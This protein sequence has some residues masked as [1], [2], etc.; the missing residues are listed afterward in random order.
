MANVVKSN[1]GGPNSPEAHAMVN[2][3]LHTLSEITSRATLAAKL[4]QS[5][6]GKR[7]LYEAL[8]YKL[9]PE[10]DDYLALY[11]RQELARAVINKPVNA[12]WSNPPKVYDS[13]AK[14]TPFENQWEE[15]CKTLKVWYHFRRV[16]RLACIGRYAVL[17]IGLDDVGSIEDLGNPASVGAKPVYLN[18]Y[19]ERSAVINQWDQDPKSPRYGMP[20]SYNIAV[21]DGT[22]DRSSLVHFSRV[23]HVAHDPLESVTFGQ[24]YLEA[25]INRLW[26]LEL[27]LGGAAEGFWRGGFPGYNFKL[28]PGAKFDQNLDEFKTEIDSFVHGMKRYLRLQG[29]SVEQLGQQIADPSQLVAALHQSIACG[30]DI[31]VRILIGSERGELASSSDDQS[32]MRTIGERQ[33]QE[34]EQVILRP[35]IEKFQDLGAL[36]MTPNG[37][38]VEWPALMAKGEKE[39]AQVGALK[40][41]A[42]QLY[43]SVMSSGVQKVLPIKSFLEHVL[44]LT[45]NQMGQVEEELKKDPPPEIKTPPPS[46]F[47]NPFQKGF[48]PGNPSQDPTQPAPRGVPFR[49]KGKPQTE[50]SANRSWV[51]KLL[52]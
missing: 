49:S 9:N 26:N 34:C 12:S 6:E 36:P 17:H 48:P 20:V 42:L 10:F 5:Y 41:R 4:G 32:W 50:P 21:T 15:L 51:Q 7:K 45:P 13:V 2:E 31:P 18:T 38:E 44:H 19:S 37:F 8:G 28:D 1:G 39:Q 29:I 11:S 24:P 23:V 52:P 25:V 43:A 22:S 30:E 46:P 47:G 3:L 16:D 40:A 14:D 35:V 27:V 33:R